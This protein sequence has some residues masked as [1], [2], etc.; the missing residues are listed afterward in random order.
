MG[1]SGSFFFHLTN[2][3]LAVAGRGVAIRVRRR[4]RR[5]VAAMLGPVLV[6]GTALVPV[7]A[8]AAAAA[9]LTAVSTAVSATPAKASL[10]GSV[11]ILSTSVNG[12][13]SSA[14]AQ[15]AAALGLTGD[16]GVGSDVGCDDEGAVRDLLGDRH[17]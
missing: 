11:L 3:W 16:G 9:A 15:Q 8:V 13:T 4:T 5:T 12:G 6:G 17:R 7:T 10:S 2:Q 14:E 1:G